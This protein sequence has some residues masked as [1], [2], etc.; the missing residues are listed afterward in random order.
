MHTRIVKTACVILLISGILLSN[1]NLRGNNAPNLVRTPEVAPPPPS[2]VPSMT[3]SEI[4]QMIARNNFGYTVDNTWVFNMSPAKRAQLMGYR[5]PPMD[6]SHL[7]VTSQ[8]TLQGQLQQLP[9]SY[10]YRTLGMV[11][12]PKSQGSCGGCWAFGSVG[13]MES[14]AL[15]ESGP[16]YNI[17]EENV[18]SCNF[19]G[20]GC[21]GG[22]DEIA[23]NYLTKFG[24]SL[25]VCAPYDGSDGTPCRDCT[26]LRKL[27][28]W[29]IIG[30]GLDTENAA[31][32]D[33]VKHALTEYGP[34]FVSMYA[35]DPGFSAYSGGVYE[36][37]GSGVPDHAVLL[38]GWDDT[39]AHS[40]GTGAWIAK[41]SWGTSWGES[42]YFNIAYGSA[43][44]CEYVSAFSCTKGY[45]DKESMYYY[46]EGGWV[47][48]F[49][50]QDYDTWGA[51]QVVPTVD[52]ILEYVDF[53]AV[54]DVLN[55]QIDVYDTIS[56]A[57]PYTFGTLLSS[58]T[59]SVDKAGYYSVE[60]STK[61]AVSAGDNIII[62]VRFNTPNFQT[63]VPLDDN[64]PI[65][66]ES[67]FSID[68]STWYDLVEQ[69]YDWDVGIRGVV[70]QSEHTFAGYPGW[71]STYTF[72][73]AGDTAYC[74]DVLGMDKI[75][76]G[77]ADGGVTENP[78]GRTDVILTT[79]EHDTGNLIVV[80][81]PAVNPV[82]TEFGDIF[83]IT[84]EFH[85]GVSFEIFCEGESIYL[86]IANDYP[87][88]D[89][90]I[91]YM[92]EHNGRTVML[93]WGYGWYGTYA[94]SVLAGDSN[95][96]SAF[97]GSHMLLVR[98]NDGNSDG[99][100]QDIEITVE[101]S[102]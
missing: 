61:P 39:M 71:F 11:T 40:H 72:F 75:A 69:G 102:A 67:Y 76:Y 87:Q 29:E 28:G 24:A 86:D 38:V 35:S 49:S 74:T 42:G 50:A 66:G 13:A 88:Q 57:G 92:G 43:R 30:K 98:W 81:G 27:C 73:V 54:D 80:G 7:N 62:A 22:N 8:N 2:T 31:D 60:L 64:L 51:V 83:G 94:G 89:I 77:L 3:L 23:V 84:Y 45:D 21:S 48:A 63:P 47:G 6:L 34:L 90:C 52:G 56:G 46:D 1:G 20:A 91:V 9:S 78:E 37:W 58:Q 96:W 59:G 12:P 70:K 79:T 93:V 101:A 16:E 99:L 44:F 36:Y 19:Y 4:K 14:R 85:A 41:N 95:T 100:I 65:S 32:I 5:P 26:Y 97:S 53:W 18:L 55:Y 33:I 82:A 17:S 25:E 10:D 68:G 15:F